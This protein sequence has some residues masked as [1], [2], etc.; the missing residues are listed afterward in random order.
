MRRDELKAIMKYFQASYRGFTEGQNPTD[1]LNVWYDAF[2]DEDVLVVRQAAKNYVKSNEFAPTVAGLMKQV[3]MIKNPMTDAELWA[4]ITKATRNSTYGSIE[5]FEK[6]PE[7]CKQFVG[8]PAALKD[9]GRIEPDK[10]QTVVKGQFRKTAPV[11]RERIN[12]VNG[13]PSDVKQVLE[14]VTGKMLI[15]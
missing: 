5:E 10:L 13:L 2:K 3:E 12:A 6:L 14:N 7:V 4:C 15:E 11:I 9:L 1:V 8:S